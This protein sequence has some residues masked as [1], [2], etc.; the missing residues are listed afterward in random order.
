[1]ILRVALLLALLIPSIAAAQTDGVTR[2][3]LP[4][5]LTLLVRENPI[6]PVV[7]F[8]VMVKM[9]TRTETPATA[10]ISNLLQLLMVRGTD[11]LGG[12]EIVEAADRMGGSIDAYGDA[13][14]SE[15]TAT[16][17][18]KHWQEMLELVTAI[19][20]RPSLP[21]GT[22]GP[23]RD[24]LTR[25]IRNRA[26][27][28]GRHAT[29]LHGAR[30]PG[31]DRHGRARAVS[32]RQGLRADQGSR[33]PSGRRHGRAVLLRAPRQ[34]GARLHHF[35]PVCDP[36]GHERLRQPARHCSRER[37]Q[38]GGRP[39]ERARPRPER[40]GAG[41]GAR[42]RQ[43]L[44]PRQPGHGPADQSAA[45]LVPGLLRSRRR[46]AGV[47]RSLRRGREAGHGG[48]P[49]ARGEALPRDGAHRHR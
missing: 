43:G 45:G 18:S 38:G 24:F 12:E 30:S 39:Q 42:D 47:P 41:R 46:R 16:A 34:A 7:A 4:N 27:A 22:F 28:P 10:G 48:G 33:L 14:Y 17:L 20:L 13:D 25:Q 36:R 35:R 29:G 37:D 44:S 49:P 1:M 26:A 15:V 3:K 9:G 5:G 6:A 11:K 32:H 8:S 2:T 40:A 31:P 23:V 19:A 21:E